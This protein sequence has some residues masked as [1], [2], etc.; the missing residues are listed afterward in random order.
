MEKCKNSLNKFIKKLSDCSSFREYYG[1]LK[2]YNYGYL[3]CESYMGHGKELCTYKQFFEKTDVLTKFFKKELSDIPKE[4]WIG[5]KLPNHPYYLAIFFALMRNNFNVILLD[6]KGSKEY[7]DYVIKN[8]NLC[9]IVSD[10]PVENTSVKFINFQDAINFNVESSEN[11]CEV[12]DGKMA[13]CTSGTTG[14][15]DIIVFS[16]KQIIHQIRSILKNLKNSPVESMYIGNSVKFLIFPPLHHV[17][18]FVALLSYS[19]IGVTNVMCKQTLSSFMGTL[20]LAKVDWSAAVPL[21][22]ESLLNFII[23]KYKVVNTSTIK[24]VVGSS[25]NLCF[26]AGANMSPSIIK[27]FSDSGIIFCNCY[28]MTE[29]GGMITWNLGRTLAERTNGSVGTIKNSSCNIKLLA[30]SGEIIEK[31]VGELLISGEGVYTFALENGKEVCR[32]SLRLD[33]FMKTGDLVEIKGGKIYFLDRI[34]DIII[35]SS[36]ENISANELERY[37]STSLKN[38]SFTVLGLND[39]PSIVVFIQDEKKLENCKDLLIDKIVKRNKRLPLNKKV[40]SVY[41]TTKPF[42]T[43]SALKVKKYELKNMIKLFPEN[44]VEVNLINKPKNLMSLEK[45]ITDLKKFFGTY[46]NADVKEI[47]DETLVIEDLNIDSLIIAELFI[48]IQ[49]KYKVDIEQDFIKIESVT[50]ADVA[51]MIWSRLFDL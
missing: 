6:S 44:Y 24:K 49:E 38:V 18:G 22:W 1:L 46:L 42:P 29:A 27:I 28:G 45:I 15:Y 2:R 13:I 40:A 50:I 12:F 34:K 39:Y 16:G 30:K 33:H 26:S 20:K 8:S 7:L 41:F 3:F 47:T 32:N 9:A 21:I 43:T 14:Y 10:T 35:N 37:F 36:G 23:G 11:D 17:F 25:L 51:N 4:S 31:G 48:H 19:I 5:I